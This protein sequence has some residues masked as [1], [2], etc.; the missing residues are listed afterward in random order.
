[1]KGYA[2]SHFIFYFTP[3]QILSDK[4]LPS[5]SGHILKKVFPSSMYYITRKRYF[6]VPSFTKKTIYH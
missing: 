2:E 1:M 3:V 4:D 6:F 5:Y